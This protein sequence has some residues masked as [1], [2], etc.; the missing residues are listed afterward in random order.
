MRQSRIICTKPKQVHYKKV[1]HKI[2]DAYSKRS[3]TQE[4]WYWQRMQEADILLARTPVPRAAALPMARTS[5][6][7]FLGVYHHPTASKLTPP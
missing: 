2:L 6:S 5:L 4:D 1:A 3:Y 7:D